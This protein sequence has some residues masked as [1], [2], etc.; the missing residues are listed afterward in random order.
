MGT[1]TLLVISPPINKTFA[2]NIEAE[3]R[4]FLQTTSLP[5]K[6]EEKIILV[7]GK[8]AIERDSNPLNPLG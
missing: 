3:F 4:N 1:I 2:L 8:L 7:L 6:S 5:W